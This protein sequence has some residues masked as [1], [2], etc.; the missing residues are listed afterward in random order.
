MLVLDLGYFQNLWYQTPESEK[1]L[2]TQKKQ[3]FRIWLKNLAPGTQYY[4]GEGTMYEVGT[5]LVSYF[6][7]I[8]LKTSVFDKADFSWVPQA[9]LIQDHELLIYFLQS[10]KDSIVAG[11]TNQALGQAG[12][13][14]PTSNG[15]ISEV[16][17]NVNEGDAQF[18]RLVANA[19]F[20]EL[21]HNKL[22][23]YISGGVVRDIHTL[24][25]GGLAVG[26]PLSN[27]LRPS[28]QN[29]QLMANAL[30]KSHPQYKVDLSRA[31]PYP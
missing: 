21:M 15:V 11:Q 1:T 19:A 8:C 4:W 30:A 18:G 31:S 20:H 13:T 10:S 28:P 6:N 22:D 25:G 5:V 16:Y 9:N 23:A 7:Q 2:M 29:I 3:T 26:T 12:A 24:G 27:A 17:L 14:F